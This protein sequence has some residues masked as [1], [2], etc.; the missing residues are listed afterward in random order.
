MVVYWASY[1]DGRQRVLLLT[2]DERIARRARRAIDAERSHLEL[3]VSISG[4]GLSLVSLNFVW[5][6]R[7]RKK[8]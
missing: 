2:Q 6:C 8:P 3:F 5:F 7:S 1:L 4:V